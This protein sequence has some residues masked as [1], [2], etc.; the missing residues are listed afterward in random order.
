[1]KQKTADYK[2][3]QNDIRDLIILSDGDQFEWPF[4][5]DEHVYFNVHVGLSNKAAD[6]DNIIKPLLDTYQSM[7]EPFNDKNVYGISL[8]KQVVSRGDEYLD[9]SIIGININDSNDNA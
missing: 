4:G 8:M 1:M 5:K 3:Y 6:L 9:V 7:Y 2:N